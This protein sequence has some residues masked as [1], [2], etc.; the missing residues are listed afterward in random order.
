MTT[1]GVYAIVNV[2][3]GRWYIGSSSEVEYRLASHV[4]KL[5]HGRHHCA[6]LQQAWSADGEQAF[7]FQLIETVAS[8]ALLREREQ[9]HIDTSEN[10]YNTALNADAP[11]LGRRHSD[12]TRMKISQRLTGV[13]QAA[14]GPPSAEKRA[15]ISA[16][17][18]GI[19]RGPMA[20]ETKEKLR[21]AA[22][23]AGRRPSVEQRTAM[24]AARVGT[25]LAPEH[26]ARIGAGLKRYHAA[27]KARV[28]A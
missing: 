15:A 28:A 3:A 13:K 10:P 16:K 22:L 12:T 2:R 20:D 23:A 17:L 24:S 4:T 5:R 26:R 7:V 6:A 1:I 19:A 25:T 11:M 18:K 8:V 27:R 9:H 21:K 14:K